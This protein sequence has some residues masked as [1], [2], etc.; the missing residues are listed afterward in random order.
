LSQS[1]ERIAPKG[2][3]RF[4][5][6][7]GEKEMLET[8]VIGNKDWAMGFLTDVDI[9]CLEDF[10]CEMRIRYLQQKDGQQKIKTYEQLVEEHGSKVPIHCEHGVPL[11]RKCGICRALLG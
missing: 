6:G 7:K 1:G 3:G 2:G 10:D 8:K 4:S 9:R 11:N 5:G